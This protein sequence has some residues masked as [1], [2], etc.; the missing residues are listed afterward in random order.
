M[1]IQSANGKRGY[2]ENEN[3]NNTKICPD[4]IFSI[5]KAYKCE[6][7]QIEHALYEI[8]L[9]YNCHVYCYNTPY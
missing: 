6:N 2:S 9:H 3:K 4:V 8:Q 1:C 5:T 7:I